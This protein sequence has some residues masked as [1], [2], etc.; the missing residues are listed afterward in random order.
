[1]NKTQG[2][3]AGNRVD[4]LGGVD[5]LEI[6]VVAAQ[7]SAHPHEGCLGCGVCLIAMGIF[8]FLTAMTSAALL[9]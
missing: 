1:M 6:E 9:L 2:P 8:G 4:R 7:M 5:E 3:K